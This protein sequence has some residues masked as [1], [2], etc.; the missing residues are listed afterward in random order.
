MVTSKDLVGQRRDSLCSLDAGRADFDDPHFIVPNNLMSFSGDHDLISST[1]FPKHKPQEEYVVLKEESAQTMNTLSDLSIVL[2][3]SRSPVLNMVLPST[4]ITSS[5]T[6]EEPVSSSEDSLQSITPL[7]TPSMDINTDFALAF[8]IDGVLMRGGKPIPEAIEAMKYINGENPYGIRVPY[9]FVT[10]GGGKTEQERCQDLSQQLEIDVS[11][12]QFICGHTPMREMA[13]QYDTVLVVGGEGEKCRVVAEGYGFKNVITPGDIIK[14]RHDTTP[15]R[16]L[17]DDEFRDSRIVDLDKTQIQA[18]FVFADSRD[19][20]GDQQII[21]DCLVSKNGYLNQR[22]ETFN[23]GPPLFFSHNDILWSTSHEHSRIGMGALRASVEALYKAIA[24]KDLETIAFGKPQMGTF[25][26]ATRLLQ[27]W[28]QKSHG[29]DKLPSTVYFFGDTPESDIRGTN[30]FDK[31]AENE[32]F[33]ILVKT[34]VYQDGTDPRFAPKEI[35]DNVLDGVKF[36][37]ER[38]QQ[39]AT[40]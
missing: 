35:C 11:P 32:W 9:I 5:N 38:E 7:S 14:T 33:S 21:L 18:I 40:Q 12:G 3:E 34:G 15:F 1:N 6:R 37:V 29:I 26:F 19:W 2:S 22:S 4:N 24:E 8:D 16:K 23:E 36:A 25:K 20:A 13:D 30:D 10:N 28:C 27:E 17:T 39:K 31:V